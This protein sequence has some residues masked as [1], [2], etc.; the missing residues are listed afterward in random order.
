MEQLTITN[1]IIFNQFKADR[2]IYP[3]EVESNWPPGCEA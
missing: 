2:E 1:P 3:E